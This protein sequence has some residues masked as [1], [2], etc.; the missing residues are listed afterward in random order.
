M[1][2]D[3]Q[4]KADV[5]AELRWD[6]AIDAAHIGV[7][8][9]DGVV[10]LRGK[11]DNYLEK[12]AAERAARR[13]AGVRGLA[14]DLEVSPARHGPRS[15]ADIAQAAVHALRWH[16]LVPADKVK[17]EV[18]DGWVALTG[19]LDWGY[20]SASAEQCIRPLIGVKGISNQIRLKQRVNPVALRTDLAAALTRHAQREANHIEIKV[21]GGVVTLSGSVDSL[22]E[23]DAVIGTTSAARGVTRVVDYLQIGA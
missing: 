13:V 22:Q 9:R 10:T 15:D 17:V 7:A 20:Q 5:S 16:S 11:V 19:E 18:E 6:A 21:D 1:K 8:V 3:D 4:L 12:H 2:T 23:H 14:I